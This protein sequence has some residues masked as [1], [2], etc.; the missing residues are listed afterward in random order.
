LD[1]AMQN[2]KKKL[3]L[4]LH[5]DTCC[6]FQQTKKSDTLQN[7]IYMKYATTLKEKDLKKNMKRERVPYAQYY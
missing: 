5:W 7:E 4:D 2:T 6:T 1:E 3:L